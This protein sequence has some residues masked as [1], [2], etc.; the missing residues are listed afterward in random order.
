MWSRRTMATIADSPRQPELRDG[1][2]AGRQLVRERD[3]EQV[4]GGPLEA[5]EV[6][7]RTDR[8][9]LLDERRVELRVETGTSTPQLSVNSH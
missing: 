7:E 1:P 5:H 6:H 9:S 8:D 2:T 4:R 3:L